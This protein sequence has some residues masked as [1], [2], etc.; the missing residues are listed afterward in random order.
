[1][2][3]DETRVRLK[4]KRKPKTTGDSRWRPWTEAEDR[5]LLEA[6]TTG[7]AGR[8]PRGVLPALTK[9]LGRT[10]DAVVQRRR[11]LRQRAA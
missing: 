5:A 6:P 9:R 3:E 1:L 4:P 7:A 2:T 11:M 10:K 8:L